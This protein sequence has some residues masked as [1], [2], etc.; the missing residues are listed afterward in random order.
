MNEQ[1]SKI[2]Q[3]LTTTQIFNNLP[4]EHLPA[5][6]EIAKLQTYQKKRTDFLGRRNK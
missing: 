4:L 2:S 5:V 3:F 1:T 6:T